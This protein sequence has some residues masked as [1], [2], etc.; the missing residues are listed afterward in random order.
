ML[1]SIDENKIIN[2][3]PHERDFRIWRNR[4]TDAEYQAIVDELNDRVN[5]DEIHT[6][7][8]IPGSDWTR[9][10]WEP[11]YTKACQNNE[12]ESGL[13]FGLIVWVV[14]MQHP[15]TWS[16]GRYEKNGI[17]IRGLTYFRVHL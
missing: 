17:P 1:Y 3:I 16:F 7:S 6:S 11:I 12:V 13:C 14:M 8:W 15:E 2:Y 4:L 9:T 5:G 10:V